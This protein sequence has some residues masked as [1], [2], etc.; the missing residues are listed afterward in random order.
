MITHEPHCGW[1]KR[2]LV[3]GGPHVPARIWMEQPIDPETG[4]LVGDEIMRCEINGKLCDAE[5]Q[6][7]YI[8]YLPITE[9]EYKFMVANAEWA[10]KYA[11]NEP[12]AQPMRAVNF[13]K[14]PIDF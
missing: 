3:R 14:L 2:K 13:N 9:A 8:C 7:T 5:E 10:A 4:E 1:F 11:P 6:W 12:A